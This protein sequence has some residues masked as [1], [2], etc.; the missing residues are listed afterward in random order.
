MTAVA[1]VLLIA[2]CLPGIVADI[3]AIWGK[4]E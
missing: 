4:H 3:R 1:L 2:L